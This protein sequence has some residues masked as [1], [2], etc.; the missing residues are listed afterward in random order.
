M[1]TGIRRINVE[2]AVLD[3]RCRTLAGIPGELGR[4]IYLAATRDYN[5]GQYHHEGLASQ[6]TEEVARGALALCHE[7]VFNRLAL[8]SLEQLVEEL[9]R[10]VV[11]T[12]ERPED[13]LTAWATLEPYRVAIPMDSAPLAAKL[14][15]SNLGV[16]VAVLLARQ[17]AGPDSQQS[18]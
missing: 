12:R 11:S 15:T 16:A 18:A 7:E 10:Y 8:S 3:L 4:L 17:A 2:E 14:F 1:S 13:L 5:T 6:F 9:D